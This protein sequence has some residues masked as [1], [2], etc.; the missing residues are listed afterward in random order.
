MELT[1]SYLLKSSKGHDSKAFIKSAPFTEF[2]E[3]TI[4]MSSTDCGPSGSTLPT[5]YMH[6]GEGKIPELQW[7]TVDG[8]K[9]WLIIVEDPDAPLPTPICHGYVMFQVSFPC[10]VVSDI[11][12][13]YLAIA[14][15]K[16]TFTNSDLE[17]IQDT[18]LRGCYYGMN[19]R[20]VV[21]MPPR[22]LL[23]HGIHR[24]MYFRG[25][26]FWDRVLTLGRYV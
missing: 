23:N 22:P 13:I 19:R 4:P 8:C 17:C 15:S 3:P 14:A 21:Y 16:T 5:E 9:Q 10:G 1:L 26:F 6:G 12:R 18:K 7:D 24:C 25:C 2:P 11:C 20:G